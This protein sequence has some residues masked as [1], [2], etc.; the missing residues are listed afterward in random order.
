MV[1]RCECL[2]C[3]YDLPAKDFISLSLRHPYG[4]SGAVLAVCY[5]DLILINHEPAGVYIWLQEGLLVQHGIFYPLGASHL[6]VQERAVGHGDVGAYRLCL[7]HLTDAAVH[8]HL[9]LS[10]REGGRILN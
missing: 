4:Q 7:C 9:P 3:V 5:L 8:T 2:W 1:I 6:L 10:P